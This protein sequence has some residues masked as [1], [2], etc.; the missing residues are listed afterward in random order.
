M[1][2]I[3]LIGWTALVC[4][5]SGPAIAQG[6]AITVIEFAGGPEQVVTFNNPKVV[7]Y[8]G[9]DTPLFKADRNYLFGSASKLGNTAGHVFAWDLDRKK[10]RIS[11]AGRPQIWLACSEIKTMSIACATTL[12]I[13]N[14][15]SLVIS[16]SGSNGGKRGAEPYEINAAGAARLPDCPGDPRCP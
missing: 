9:T 16:G 4:I 5:L 6:F 3:K 8:D 11:A 13:A 2:R 15:G 14:D 12:R 7:A 10:V 1:R